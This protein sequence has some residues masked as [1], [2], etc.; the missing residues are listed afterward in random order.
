M[1]PAGL[2]K[3]ISMS[4]ISVPHNLEC[5]PHIHDQNAVPECFLLFV[6]QVALTKP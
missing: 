4:K 1:K 5:D 6:G 3:D 2:A